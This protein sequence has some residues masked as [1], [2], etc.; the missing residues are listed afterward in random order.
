[1]HGLAEEGGC[2][3][4]A[5][6]SALREWTVPRGLISPCIKLSRYSFSKSF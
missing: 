4:K 6:L 1:M 2:F 3:D 5:A